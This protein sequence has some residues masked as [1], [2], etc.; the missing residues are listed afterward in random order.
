MSHTKVAVY[1]AARGGTIYQHPV[2]P[3][4][5]DRFSI[6]DRCFM[7]LFESHLLQITCF[8]VAGQ[9]NGDVTPTQ[10]ITLSDKE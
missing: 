7:A 5:H 9:L 6:C 8:V 2:I 10:H 4:N 3:H 1:A